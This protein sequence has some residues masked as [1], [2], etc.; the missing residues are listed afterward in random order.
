MNNENITDIIQNAMMAV[1]EVMSITKN[2][3]AIKMPRTGAE[4]KAIADAL[5]DV[6]R[7][8]NTK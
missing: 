2:N 1:V 8:V 5:V 4:Y 3:Q 6:I 7:H